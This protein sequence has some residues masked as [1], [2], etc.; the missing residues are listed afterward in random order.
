M[1]S[2]VFIIVPCVIRS[3][4]KQSPLLF[5]QIKWLIQLALLH[6]EASRYL[7]TGT[8]YTNVVGLRDC[9]TAGVTPVVYKDRLGLVVDLIA[10]QSG[11]P[12]NAVHFL[13]CIT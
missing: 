12:H 9:C 6:I 7:Y 4:G 1:K 2:R 11:E 13:W 5:V 10:A 3:I 8:D